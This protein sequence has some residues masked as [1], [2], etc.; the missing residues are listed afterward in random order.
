MEGTSG[1]ASVSNTDAPDHRGSD[2][3]AV[4]DI[5]GERLAEVVEASAAVSRSS[6]GDAG[7][8]EQQLWWMR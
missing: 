3:D 4:Q 5:P 2:G 7:N 6:E 1:K 8:G